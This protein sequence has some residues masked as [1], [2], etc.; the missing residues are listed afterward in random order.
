MRLDWENEIEV[1]KQG[2]AV[3]IYLLPNMFVTMGLVVLVVV[4]G[5]KMDGNLVTIILTLIVAGLACL[6]Y[7]KVMK[8]AKN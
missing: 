3:S 2:A 1:I 7:R 4:L 8:L 6:S 5:M